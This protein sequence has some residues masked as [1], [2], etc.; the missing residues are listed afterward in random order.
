MHGKTDN[1]KKWKNNVESIMK[2]EA[3]IQLLESQ[4]KLENSYISQ[5]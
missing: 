5:K 1:H 4:K 2:K 3:E